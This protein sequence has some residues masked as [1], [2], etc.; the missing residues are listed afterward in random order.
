ML[1]ICFGDKERNCAGVSRRSFLQ[2]GSLGFGGLT[3][4][5]LLATRA[6]GESQAAAK[7]QLRRTREASGQ[8]GVRALVQ[9]ADEQP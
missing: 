8:D 9:R 5:S 7:W 4:S 1:Q 2:V 3:L 6:A